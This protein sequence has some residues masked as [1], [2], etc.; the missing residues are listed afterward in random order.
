MDGR[1]MGI[2]SMS[3]MCCGTIPEETCLQDFSGM[4][5][6]FR[7]QRHSLEMRAARSS[8][9]G[10]AFRGEWN[11]APVLCHGALTRAA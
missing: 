7:S 9:H 2:R 11:G 3:P 8:G 1:G 10:M 6:S 5:R 4:T